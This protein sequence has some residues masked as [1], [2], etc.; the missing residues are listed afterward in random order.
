MV[1]RGNAGHASIDDA[2]LRD[3]A[4]A[5]LRQ[6]VHVA[7]DPAMSA[8]APRLRPARV[9]V[10]LKDGRRGTHAC[11]SHRGDFQRP[12]EESEIRGKFH[13]LAGLVLTLEGS[14]RAEE[15]ADRC[16]H[17]TS[18]LELTNLL[19]RHGRP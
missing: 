15:A 6:R 5:A 11:E 17:W 12:F 14:A 9:T 10:M 7:E 8:V 18:A 3:P 4:I 2:A 13:E 1:V 16:E 19:R